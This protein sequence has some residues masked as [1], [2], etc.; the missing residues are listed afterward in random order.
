MCNSWNEGCKHF[1]KTL[2]AGYKPRISHPANCCSLSKL[3]LANMS[4][5]M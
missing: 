3:Y 4:G 1:T 5:A 2:F